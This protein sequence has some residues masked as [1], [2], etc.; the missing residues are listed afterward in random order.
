M[1]KK[2]V[3]DQMCSQLGKWLR[4]AG[5]DTVI[6][7]TSMP[8]EKIFQMDLEEHRFLLTRD[9]VLKELDPQQKTIIYL[10]SE[11]LDDWAFQLKDEAE[12]DWLFNPFSRCLQCNTLLEKT[13]RPSDDQHIP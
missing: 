2:F 4:I 1:I 10:R 6:I 5:Y 8:D 9:R 3:C 11:N 7:E 13:P 12:V